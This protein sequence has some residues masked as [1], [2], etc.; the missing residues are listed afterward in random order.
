MK[1]FIYISGIVIINFFVF[2]AIFKV[3]H[4]PGGGILI[5]LGLGLFSLGFLPL[6]FIKSY[7]G[8]GRKYKSLY[9]AGFICAFITFVGAMF[10]IQHWPGAG[11]FL[12]IGIPLPFL[13]FLPVYIYHQNRSKEKSGVNFLGVMFL[14]VYVAIFT[15][16]LALNV[17][18]DILEAFNTGESDFAKTNEIL[19][20]RTNRAYENLSK[21]GISDNVA[22][23]SMIKAKSDLLYAKLHEVK[24][25]LIKSAE[26][27]DSPAIEGNNIITDN[28]S[29]WD[30]S[31]AT[32]KELRGSNGASGRAKELKE[33]I[34]GYREYLKTLFHEKTEASNNIDIL[35][36]TSDAIDSQYD[37]T[38]AIL[39][40]DM[41]F[42]NGLILATALTS[43]DCIEINARLAE[44]EALEQIN[45]S[46]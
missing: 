2:G 29:A 9:I 18:R 33:M 46:Y 15:S 10:K 31:A 39:W 43:L 1:K 26:G 5:M 17:S 3:Q 13:Y 41:Y 22:E 6:S 4:W 45:N 7:Q 35:L 30:E 34:I 36:S 11:L 37:P 40:E 24:I 14:M 25:D 20:A 8:N 21:G 44:A 23:I 42:P 12:L 28:I 27:E 38:K 16:I 32:T 19:A